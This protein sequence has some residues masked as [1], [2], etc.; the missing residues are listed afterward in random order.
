MFSVVQSK[1]RSRKDIGFSVQK[2]D[3]KNSII[4]VRNV[5]GACIYL[6]LEHLTVF[7]GFTGV[8]G[9]PWVSFDTAAICKKL[10]DWILRS[11]IPSG[12]AIGLRK[13]SDALHKLFC[14]PKMYR[15]WGFHICLH[16]ESLNQKW[17]STW[18]TVK[19]T[20]QSEA[21]SVRNLYLLVSVIPPVQRRAP[22]K[23]S[24]F[25]GWTFSILHLFLIAF[26]GAP[27]LSPGLFGVDLCL[28][29]WCCKLLRTGSS[30]CSSF[31]PTTPPLS[32]ST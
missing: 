6:G 1:P 5:V 21:K 22:L 29:A 4:F 12:W 30:L 25:I 8:F 10:K 17:S 28:Y 26:P 13:Q 31:S 27:P 24:C 20:T 16:V 19:I 2:L 11:I 18:K 9:M 32:S 23:F 15:L 14:F 3:V 7:V